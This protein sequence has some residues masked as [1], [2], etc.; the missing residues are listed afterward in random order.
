MSF[1]NNHPERREDEV[2]FT[3]TDEIGFRGLGW[4]TKRAGTQAY[5]RIGTPSNGFFPVFVKQSEI[6]EKDPGILNAL[7]P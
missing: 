5:T 6:S 7:L 1:N 4:E 2:F 3:N